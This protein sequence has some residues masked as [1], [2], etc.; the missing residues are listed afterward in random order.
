MEKTLLLT[1]TNNKQMKRRY[2]IPQTVVYAL[3]P[4]S[5]L[6]ASEVLENGELGAPGLPYPDDDSFGSGH[7]ED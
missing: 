2:L 5:L 7:P 4:C 3:P 1:V 6:T